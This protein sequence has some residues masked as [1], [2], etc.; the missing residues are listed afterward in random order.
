M[1]TGHFRC[2][3]DV[4]PGDYARQL[5][6]PVTADEWP[7]PLP[8]PQLRT[9]AGRLRLPFGEPGA[10]IGLPSGGGPEPGGRGA[11]LGRVTRARAPARAE[12][13]AGWGSPQRSA[14]GRRGEER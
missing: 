10:V 7:R 4:T 3:S 8:W 13:L 1:A 5:P 11:A 14:R 9:G 12:G 6:D 2:A